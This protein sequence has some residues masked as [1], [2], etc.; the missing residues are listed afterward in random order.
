MM[1]LQNTGDFYYGGFV[2]KRSPSVPIVQISLMRGRTEEQKSKAAA[3]ITQILHEHL[4]S[5]PDH[6]YVVF[7][8]VEPSNWA[9]AGKL[10]SE[11]K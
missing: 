9:I 7:Q 11:K 5:T 1:A 8:D 6:T 4:N 2:Y 3:A 10:L